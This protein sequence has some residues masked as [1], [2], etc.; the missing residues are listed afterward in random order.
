M[1]TYKKVVEKDIVYKYKVFMLEEE[2]ENKIV[3]M[4]LRQ[5]KNNITVTFDLTKLHD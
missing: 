5:A 3:N 1:K 2:T 4:L